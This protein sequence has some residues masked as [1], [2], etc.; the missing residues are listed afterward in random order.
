MKKSFWAI[1]IIILIILA[2]WYLYSSTEK[3]QAPAVPAVPAAEPAPAAVNA[4]APANIPP[5]LKVSA[6][7]TLG[8]ILVAANGLTLYEYAEDSAGTSN[9]TDTCAANWPPYTVSADTALSGE[10]DVPGA[11]ATITRADGS[12]QVTYNGLPLYFYKNDTNAGDTAG[13]NVGGVWSV[14][15]P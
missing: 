8:N 2:G 4:P 7:P 10:G 15:K 13:Q 9:C 6:D 5:I 1:V 14:V 3:V 11:I 12:L